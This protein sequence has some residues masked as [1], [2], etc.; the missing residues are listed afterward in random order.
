MSELLKG[1][2]TVTQSEDFFDCYPAV[3]AAFNLAKLFYNGIEEENEADEKLEDE[4]KKKSE[5]EL[6]YDE[7]KMF[8]WFLGQYF[9]FCQV[10]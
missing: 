7:F 5:D 9:I 6:V 1:V 8:F 2:A 3:R 10:F 4:A